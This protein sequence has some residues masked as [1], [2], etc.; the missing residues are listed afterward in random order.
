M[1]PLRAVL[2]GLSTRPRLGEAMSR[3]PAT[4]ALVRRFVAGT[5]AADA[6]DVLEGLHARGLAT[7]VTYLGENVRTEAEAGRAADVYVRLVDEIGRRRLRCVPSLKL[8]HLGLDVSAAACAANVTRVLAR[9]REVGTRV[10]I[11]MESSAYTDRTLDLYVRLRPEWPNA[12]CVVQAALRRTPADVERLI[13][14]A[15]AVRLCKGA[16]REPAAIAYADRADVDAA[17]A[18]LMDRLLAPDARARGVYPAFATHD[19]RLIRRARERAT[20]LG[21]AADAFEMQMLHG[22]RPDLH[23]ALPAA[24]LALRVLVPFGE[25]WYGYFMRRLAERPANLVFLLRNL[26]RPA[27][28]GI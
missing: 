16:Y 19:E 11:D 1:S 28:R 25:D 23:A 3:L 4:R 27:A 26:V 17:Y 12:A 2:L 9:A 10:W 7:A 15:A 20:A 24:G 6:L 13:A 14:A 8:T 18:R 21:V 22:I 5:T